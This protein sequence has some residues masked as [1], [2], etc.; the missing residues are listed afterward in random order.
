METGLSY[1][2]RMTDQYPAVL[3]SSTNS[4]G[5]TLL[6]AFPELVVP[7]EGSRHQLHGGEFAAAQG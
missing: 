3:Y 6:Q 5:V 7:I 2:P 4:G 1:L